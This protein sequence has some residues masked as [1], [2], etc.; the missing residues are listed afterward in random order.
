MKKKLG[1][2]KNDNQCLCVSMTDSGA[3]EDHHTWWDFPAPE[4]PD[5]PPPAVDPPPLVFDKNAVDGTEA[6]LFCL[7]TVDVRD[8]W[9]VTYPEEAMTNDAHLIEGDDRAA[10]AQREREEAEADARDKFR[11]P[12]PCFAYVTGHTQSGAKV[13]LVVPWRPA[14]M[15]ECAPMD[16]GKEALI[17]SQAQLDK[18]LTQYAE[19]HRLRRS[20]FTITWH[21]MCRFNG[22]VPTPGNPTKRRE[23]L[24]ARVA[25]PNKEL[26]AWTADFVRNNFPGRVHEDGIDAEQMFID[27]NKMTP[28]GWHRVARA[29]LVPAGPEAREMLVHYEFQVRPTTLTALP[30]VPAP[31]VQALPSLVLVVLDAEMT[32]GTAGR[33]PQATRPEDAVVVVSAVCAYMGGDAPGRPPKTV[34]RRHAFVLAP[35]ERCLPIPGA[36]VAY[37]DCE[38]DLLAAVRDFCFVEHRADVVSGHNIVTFDMRYMA[39]RAGMS[40]DRD[41]APSLNRFARFGAL[42]WEVVR[43]RDRSLNSSGLGSNPLYLLPGAGF[44]YV[45]SMLICKQHPKKLR[46]HTLAAACAE[47]LPAGTTK[48]DMPYEAIP[49]IVGSTSR[50]AWTALVGYC[51][52]DSELVFKLLCVWDTVR[53]LVAQSRVINIPLATNT[54]CGQQQR[55]RNSLL[56]KARSCTPPM[57]MNKVNERGGR[58]GAGAAEV[59]TADGGCVLDNVAGLHDVPVAVLDFASLYPSVQR[60]RNLCWSTVVDPDTLAGLS[61]EDRAALGIAEYRTTTGTFYFVTNVTGVFPAQLKDLLLA[62]NA[63]KRDM[64]QAEKDIAAAKASGDAHALYLAQSAYA[65]ADAKQRGTKIVMNSGY[66]TANVT[67]GVMPCRA[68]GTVTCMVGAQLNAQAREFVERTFGART[69]YGDTDS[70]MVTFPEPAH[71]DTNNPAHRLPRLR[72][73]IAMGVQAQNALNSLFHDLEAQRRREKAAATGGPLEDVENIVQTE[74]EKTYF[75]FNTMKKKVYTGVKFERDPGPDADPTLAG[76]GHIEAKGMKMVRRDV[77]GFTKALTEALLQALLVQ[78]SLDKFWDVARDF[79]LRV[80]LGPAEFAQGGRPDPVTDWSP[81][82]Q[83]PLPMAAF[84]LT[85]EL[86]AGFDTKEVTTPQ[87]AVAFAAEQAR[88]GSGPQVGD[89]VPFVIVT[90]ADVRRLYKTGSKSTSGGGGGSSSTSA[91]TDDKKRAAHARSPTEVRD[92]PEANV[93][94]VEFYVSEGICKVVEQLCPGETTTLACTKAREFSRAVQAAITASRGPG[95]ASRDLWAGLNVLQRQAPVAKDTATIIRSLPPLGPLV[96]RRSSAAVTALPVLPGAMPAAMP[97]AAAMP[98]PET[99]AKHKKTAA[100]K[101]REKEAAEK[102]LQK[103][104]EYFQQFLLKK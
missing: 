32:T 41:A 52:Q 85:K 82:S 43:P 27:Y 84:V 70:I 24:Y 31:D 76:L 90:A 103:Q 54:T 14:F 13:G 6:L 51:I 88:P 72:H 11:S 45:D 44:A 64:K 39:T 29:V 71:L 18:R 53:D 21:C 35:P 69:L 9:P 20:S 89:R 73:A 8:V 78:R 94:D 42:A 91:A 4:F 66:G 61:P 100:E 62:R 59:L 92:N 58:R 34:F 48:H 7:H 5:T 46:Q 68:V 26:A 33:F 97:T 75:P 30:F 1:D 38:Q 86:K 98:A 67:E 37:F 99:A 49:G 2:N 104:Q 102:V 80:C 57:V 60:S 65:N 83:P 25:C 12:K 28:S 3:E 101:R 81:S 55:V 63:A 95:R 87:A 96:R 16:M 17:A 36:T 79:V 74:H 50:R 47:F 10:E 93:L 22:Y 77:P 19:R 56:L 40:P 15:V 23:F